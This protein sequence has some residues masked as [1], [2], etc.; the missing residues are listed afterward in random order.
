MIRLHPHPSGSTFAIP[1]IAP[2]PIIG[3]P[4]RSATL[5]FTGLPVRIRYNRRTFNLANDI[6]TPQMPPDCHRYI[7][8][9]ACDEIFMKHKEEGQSMYYR[10]K[11][12][13]ELQGARKRWLTTRAG[14]YVKSDFK[15]GPV[16]GPAFR[17]LTWKP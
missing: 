10:R 5:G 1:A 12:E 7:V 13:E 6:D 15:V 3:D 8:Y 9:A 11:A 2:Q 17:S 14:P 16:Y 4:G